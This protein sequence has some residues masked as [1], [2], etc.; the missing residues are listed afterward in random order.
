MGWIDQ[1]QDLERRVVTFRAR[2]SAE[3]E[4]TLRRQV[5]EVALGWRVSESSVLRWALRLGL[6]ELVGRRSTGRDVR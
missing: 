3:E 2:L 4:R 1:E 5:E 6:G